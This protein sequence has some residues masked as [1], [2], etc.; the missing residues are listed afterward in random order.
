MLLKERV[1]DPRAVDE[2]SNALA[3]QKY[4]E[5]PVT[6]QKVEP[7]WREVPVYIYHWYPNTL[8]AEGTPTLKDRTYG[9]FSKEQPR[10]T[11]YY[12][13]LPVKTVIDFE[14]A[15]PDPFFEE[16]KRQ[17]CT[18]LKIA[19]VPVYL[20]ERLLE[21]EFKQR[22][23]VAVRLAEQGY[24]A[25]LDKLALDSVTVEGR[26]T[27]P[28]LLAYIDQHAMQM[29]AEDE[30]RHGRVLRG[31]A[32]RHMMRKYKAQIVDDLRRGLKSGRIVDPYARYRQP[33][34]AAQ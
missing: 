10:F 1:M 25:M 7:G 16:V 34:D 15:P 18:E 21:P 26:L 24:A 13:T 23:E 29:I 27:E 4:A 14:P 20:E 30:A 3:Y 11:R 32:K 9:P 8:R 17:W 19:Y 5:D 31:V 33:A 6:G 28:E 22:V 2:I 12:P